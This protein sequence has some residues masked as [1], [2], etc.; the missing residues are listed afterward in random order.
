MDRLDPATVHPAIPALVKE[1]AA[2][3]AKRVV[4]YGSRARGDYADRSDIDIAVDF[5]GMDE[6]TWFTMQDVVENAETL[7]KIDCVW[8]QKAADDLKKNI[9]RDGKILYERPA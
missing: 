7:Y 3:G 8:L 9:M 2:L 4:L 6:K 1:L 5:A